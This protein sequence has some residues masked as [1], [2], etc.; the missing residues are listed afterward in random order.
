M[1]RWWDAQIDKGIAITKMR[2]K[3]MERNGMGKNAMI[4]KKRLQE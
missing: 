3:H 2:I 4:E 1:V